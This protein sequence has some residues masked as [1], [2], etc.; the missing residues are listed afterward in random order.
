MFDANSHTGLVLDR[1]NWKLT[2][3]AIIFWGNTFFKSDKKTGKKN[4]EII[5]TA[6]TFGILFPTPKNGG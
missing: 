5:G 1:K 2:E 3:K 6:L 4:N